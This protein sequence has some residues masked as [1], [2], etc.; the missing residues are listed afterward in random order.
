VQAPEGTKGGDV[1]NLA[2]Q[3]RG[4]LPEDRPGV[5]AVVATAGGKASIVVAAN[6]AAQ[7]QHVSAQALVK[8]ALS[9]KGGGNDEVAQGGGVPADQAASLLESVV[10]A[11]PA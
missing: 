10:G 6:K 1:R 5:A 3:I 11:I 8:A 4:H 2:M 9:G 7:A